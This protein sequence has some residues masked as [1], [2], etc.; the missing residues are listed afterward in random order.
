MRQFLNTILFLTCIVFNTEEIAA[1]EIIQNL[2]IIDSASEQ[3]YILTSASDIFNPA[4]C[5]ETW[6]YSVQRVLPTFLK[7]SIIGDKS[8]TET[9]SQ[10]KSKINSYAAYAENHILRL[11]VTDIIH[12]FNYFW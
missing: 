8:A 10:R 2:A 4:A 11:E 1:K 3:Q 7:Y 6:Q 9:P 5:R 12:P